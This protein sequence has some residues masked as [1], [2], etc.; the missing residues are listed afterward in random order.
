MANEEES[1]NS[2]F[3]KREAVVLEI[4]FQTETSRTA[5]PGKVRRRTDSKLVP[6][7]SLF[8]DV[9]SWVVKLLEGKAKTNIQRV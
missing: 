9:F 5:K 4:F 8:M 7:K 1:F 2:S 3:S 6:D